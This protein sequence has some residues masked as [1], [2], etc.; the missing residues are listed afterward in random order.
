MSSNSI[1]RSSSL[2]SL[3][4]TEDEILSTKGI[5]EGTSANQDP[6]AD[7]G[8]NWAELR[9]QKGSDYWGLCRKRF[10]TALVSSIIVVLALH[11]MGN[12][13]SEGK[14]GLYFDMAAS[15]FAVGLLTSGILAGVSEYRKR[16]FKKEE[17]IDYFAKLF[18]DYQGETNRADAKYK[19]GNVQKIAKGLVVSG[20]ALAILGAAIY[21]IADM[22]W[23]QQHIFSLSQACPQGT[24]LGIAIMGSSLAFFAGAAYSI[25]KKRYWE[26]KS[27]ES[28]SPGY[29]K[30]DLPATYDKSDKYQAANRNA[31][32]YFGAKG[33]THSEIGIHLNTII[34]I[35]NDPSRSSGSWVS[36]NL[37]EQGNLFG[38]IK[39]KG[40]I[41][42]NIEK[43]PEGHYQ[44]TKKD[45]SITL[46]TADIEGIKYGNYR[47]GAIDHEILLKILSEDE[48]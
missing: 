25:R 30:L 16:W 6:I 42:L 23:A 18:R 11:F 20:I 17:T 14:Y 21:F 28:M 38:N 37:S 44:I 32:N 35:F 22:A 8:Q 45:L 13:I 40:D 41:N 27:Y 7:S 31:W 3:S 47:E 29:K 9:C 5:F 12:G 36:Y 34:K 4:S 10:I 15:P 46:S 26:R 2:S 39:L 1:S 19:A 48:A 43:T 33:V 24:E